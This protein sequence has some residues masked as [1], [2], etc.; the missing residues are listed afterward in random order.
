VASLID[1]GAR[2]RGVVLWEGRV[3]RPAR[4]GAAGAPAAA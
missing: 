3:P 2:V 1:V 4:P